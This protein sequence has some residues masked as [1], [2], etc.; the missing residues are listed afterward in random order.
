LS[1][2]FNTLHAIYIILGSRLA[3]QIK[4]DSSSL[5]LGGWLYR[6]DL[7]LVLIGFSSA[8]TITSGFVWRLRSSFVACTSSPFSFFVDASVK[9]FCSLVSSGAHV[10]PSSIL[11]S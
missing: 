5:S 10:F 7:A 4:H 3:L 9:G 1:S 11:F 6:N 2:I 8:V